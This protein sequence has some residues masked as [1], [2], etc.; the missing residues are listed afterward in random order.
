MKG[1]Q[2]LQTRSLRVRAVLFDFDGTLT[3][4]GALDFAY[5][6]RRLHCPAGE[7]ILDFIE[8]LPSSRR[9]K[10]LDF[11]HRYEMKAAASARPNEAAGGL[12]RYLKERGVKVGIVSRNR[13]PAIRR[14]LRNF[15]DLDP[16]DFDLIISRDN[17]FPPKPSGEG[18]LRAARRMGVAPG[19]TV[20]VGD[21]IHDVQAGRAAGAITVFLDN[22]TVPPADRVKSDCTI[23]HLGDLR[24]VLLAYLPLPV[25][26]LDNKHLPGL[27]RGMVLPDRTVLTGPGVGEDTAAVDIG[28]D[29]VLVLTSDPITF[30]PD[31]IGRYAVLVNA[32]DIA[33]AGARPRWLLVTALFPPGT[34]LAALR[35]D[36]G[37]L[38]KFCRKEGITVIGGHTE[39]TPAVTRPILAG[40][41]AG[42]VR[43]SAL[44][45]KSSV[46]RGDLILLTKALAAEGNSLIARRF[47]ERL[48]RGGMTER[49][50]TA[51]RKDIRLLSILPEA[52]IAASLPGVSALH[53]VTEGGLAAALR[54]LSAAAGRRIRVEMEKIPV[55]PRTVKVCRLLGLDPLCLI[56]SG[57]LLICCRKSAAVI[58]LSRLRRARIPVTRIGDAG[59]RG[60]GVKAFLN[61]ESRPWPDPPVDEI[62]RISA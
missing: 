51:C 43:R 30:A 8:S 58:L 55:S 62:A 27:L 29:S 7:Q 59:D 35:A 26:K 45:K 38:G 41:L 44:L 1:K 22:R 49:E 6:R 10:S 25:G 32:N 47:P 56:A 21:Y 40:T 13:H 19:E 17:A 61:G 52:R 48:R 2:P 5:L 4:P 28:K 50:I 31:S 37:E 3:L 33:T 54:E 23:R 15:P 53:D 46:R 18:I 36:L 20:M 11:L 57:S 16:S 42:T 14:A 24:K 60:K 39:I 34:T 12:I 9:E